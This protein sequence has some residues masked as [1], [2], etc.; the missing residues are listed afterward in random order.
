MY[1]YHRT[2]RIISTNQ[3]M[4]TLIHATSTT[5]SSLISSYSHTQI[6]TYTPTYGSLYTLGRSGQC[7]FWPRHVY[8][9]SH[10]PPTTH[11]S[12]IVTFASQNTCMI[13]CITI[14]ALLNLHVIRGTLI[15]FTHM[16]PVSF[17]NMFNTQLQPPVFHSS[18]SLLRECPVEADL[19]SWLV[20][21]LWKGLLATYVHILHSAPI[22]M[23]LYI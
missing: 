15:S 16:Y 17:N 5:S 10:Q 23:R 20:C 13:W 6:F 12:I 18:G 21:S 19:A 22:H 2:I 8:L 3:F 11:V 1:S 4:I 14:C 9:K 7:P